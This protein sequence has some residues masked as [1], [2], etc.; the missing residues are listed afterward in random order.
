LFHV[1]EVTGEMTEHLDA[2]VE[3]YN[4]KKEEE[5]EDDNDEEKAAYREAFSGLLTGLAN[6]F[7]GGIESDEAFN[8]CEL[9]FGDVNYVVVNL[10]EEMKEKEKE[11]WAPMLNVA[12]DL[13]LDSKTSVEIG[14]E[15]YRLLNKLVE[16]CKFNVKKFGDEV[17]LDPSSNNRDDE[18]AGGS[19]RNASRLKKLARAFEICGDFE[20]QKEIALISIHLLHGRKCESFDSRTEHGMK[21]IKT[22][23]PKRSEEILQLADALVKLHG[24]SSKRFTLVVDFV[25]Q[26]NALLGSAATVFS[27]EC[28]KIKFGEYE[29]ADNLVHFS[30]HLGMSLNV[31]LEKGEDV[32]TAVDVLEDNMRVANFELSTNTLT[33]GIYQKCDGMLEKDAFDAKDN[34]WISLRFKAEDVPGVK[35]CVRVYAE[36]GNC[37][38][39]EKLRDKLDASVGKK[40]SRAVE[41]TY[42][43]QEILTQPESTIDSIMEPEPLPRNPTTSKNLASEEDIVEKEK[44]ITKTTKSSKE[45]LLPTPPLPSRSSKPAR[46]AKTKANA[47][48]AAQNAAYQSA[49][50]EK[51]SADK[52]VSLIN[53]KK[54]TNQKKKCRSLKDN[55]ANDNDQKEVRGEGDDNQNS[56]LDQTD[57]SF[58]VDDEDVLEDAAK[59]PSFVEEDEE[60]DT[61]FDKKKT[62]ERA[63]DDI[64]ISEKT[65]NATLKVPKTA[66]PRKREKSTV[67]VAPLTKETSRGKKTALEQSTAKKKDG[68]REKMN[69]LTNTL[70]VEDEKNIDDAQLGKSDKSE[71]ET[72]RYDIAKIERRLK[73][74]TGKKPDDASTLKRKNR[75][76]VDKTDD[77]AYREDNEDDDLLFLSSQ[78]ESDEREKKRAATATK[79]LG[80]KNNDDKDFGVE[81][82]DDEDDNLPTVSAA[83]NQF[84]AIKNAMETLRCTKT[85]EAESKVQKLTKNLEMDFEKA[86]SKLTRQ[87]LENV[88]TAKRSIDDTAHQL[89]KEEQKIL[90]RLDDITKKFSRDF[91]RERE[92]L[93]AVKSKGKSAYKNANAVVKAVV[94]EAND[95]WE[96]LQAKMREKSAK[97]KRECKKIRR[98]CAEQTD[99]KTML[100]NMAEMI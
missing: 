64:N 23:F 71:K 88:Q 94:E 79:V 30:K 43:L 9:A 16:R 2:I 12:C 1:K 61:L 54:T 80:F 59:V 97:L 91:E 15:C 65:P 37:K 75:G 82:E 7:V 98:E 6:R 21:T 55:F 42:D 96:T 53:A 56:L 70:H 76:D 72:L 81:E 4:A 62:N 60:E 29:V 31:R 19:Q 36:S 51:E 18:L 99:L 63:T 44:E 35:N 28:E 17:L 27:Y 41:V 39:M 50:K 100:L 83:E 34:S 89:E 32:A 57:E 95:E 78:N 67:R 24:N 38:A 33:I 73:F 26:S 46:A 77:F 92:F 5:E 10:L 20:C 90:A 87:V 84:D 48:F 74:S 52:I 86:S 69:D 66:P 11:R 68:W 49:L 25:R 47:K 13:A 85:R 8:N 40:T 58:D 22:L 3:K 45:K 93:L 14:R